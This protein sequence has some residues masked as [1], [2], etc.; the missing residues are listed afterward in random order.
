MSDANDRAGAAFAE[1]LG[2]SQ[3]Y[4]PDLSNP[5]RTVQEARANRVDEVEPPAPDDAWGRRLK[6][7]LAE[8]NEG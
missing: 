5:D 3:P 2:R 4:Q 1:F 8:S 6:S 7:H